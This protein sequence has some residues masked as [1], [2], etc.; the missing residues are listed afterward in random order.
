MDD[1]EVVAQE[2]SEL[3]EKMRGLEERLAEVERVNARLEEAALTTARVLGESRATRTR[4]TTPC[5]A[6]TESTERSRPSATTL[7]AGRVARSA[8]QSGAT[9]QA[10]M[11]RVSPRLTST[12]KSGFCTLQIRAASS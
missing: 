1:Y 4:C 8:L 11:C 5:P 9:R 3:A 6:Q 2:L 7:P 12:A 10:Q